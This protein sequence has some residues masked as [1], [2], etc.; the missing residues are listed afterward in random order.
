MLTYLLTYYAVLGVQ[1]TNFNSVA[2]NVRGVFGAKFWP[3]NFIV[4]LHW[5]YPPLDDP[6]DWPNIKA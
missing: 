5:I 3:L 6:I 1:I 4:P 2:D